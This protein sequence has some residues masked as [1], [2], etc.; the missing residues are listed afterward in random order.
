MELFLANVDWN[1]SR[2]QVTEGLAKVLH[3]S[4]FA[5]LSPIPMNF[6]V[7][8]HP[9]RNG[10]R[11]HRGTGAL[12]LP[13]RQI[14]EHFMDLYGSQQSRNPLIIGRKTISV[15]VS[16]KPNGRRDVV[17]KITLHRYMDPYI[18]A[19]RVRRVA[20]LDSGS[21]PVQTIQF[22][23]ECRDYVFSIECEQQCDARTRLVFNVERREIRM[24][25][26]Y[27]DAKIYYI[28]IPYSNID[29]IIINHYLHR[30]AAIVFSL[31]TPP[32]Y[33]CDEPPSKLR[34]RRSYLPIPGHERVA[35]YTSLA[36]RIICPSTQNLQSFRHLCATAHLHK[37]ED[38]EY[39]IVRRE[40]FSALALSSLQTHLR[41]L[42]WQVA[43]QIESLVRRMA[44]DVQEM[45]N[46]ML[47]I[48]SMVHAEG[49][50]FTST[51]LRKFGINAKAMFVDGADPVEASIR[52]CFDNTYEELKTLKNINTLK[53]TDDSIYDAF[54]VTI[55]PTTMFLD[56]PFPER[57]NRV[58]RAYEAK[59][60]ESFLR[61]GFVDEAKMKYR[62]DREIDGPMFIRERVGPILLQG[63]KIAG[64]KFEFLAYS[65]S[66]LKEHAVW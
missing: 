47:S 6:H 16:R 13:S 49:K 5:H 42:N 52:Q 65:Q 35:P 25:I 28:A 36:I 58:L 9:E 19:E 3:G 29:S 40:I 46:L 56:G 14:G 45:L 41:R 15:S 53:P 7:Q 18:E 31:N 21:I 30:E 37:L 64:R 39:P 27:A 34:Q 50:A 60:H 43:F 26:Q 24:N 10:I 17:E 2:Q 12:T 61:V 4:L 48:E 62:F 59:H 38:Y 66:A 32:T 51:M 33:E 1:L 20:E 22:G 57:S 54:H 11:Q 23:W 55:T 8:L 63:L 44:V